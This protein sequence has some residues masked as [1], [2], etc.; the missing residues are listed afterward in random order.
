MGIFKM[1]GIG[2]LHL[3]NPRIPAESLYKK[4]QKTLYPELNDA[5]VLLLTGDIYDQLLTVNSKAH[6]FASIIMRELLSISAH[7]GMQIRLLHGTYTHDRDQLDIFETLQHP[8]SRFKVIN[9][10]DVEELTDIRN[11]DNCIPGSLRILYIPDNLPYKKSEDVLIHCNKVM[12]CHD[13]STVDVVLGHGTFEHVI[14]PDS[15]HRP[16]CLY[17]MEQ[18]QQIN[19]IGPIIMGH[20]HTPSKCGRV[21]YCGSFERMSHGEEEN[22]GFYTFTKSEGDQFWTSRFVVNKDAT[23]FISVAP[24]GDEI[25]DIS[26]DFI[27][28]VEEKFPTRSGNVRVLHPSAEIRAILHKI[29]A[30]QFPELVYSGKASGKREVAELC[31]DEVTLDVLEDITPDVHN[32]GKLRV[33]Y[34]DEKQLLGD[35]TEEEILRRTT[36]LLPSA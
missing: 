20:I 35:V 24:I 15:G 7:T 29:C 23:P 21:Y 9:Q 26:A 6:K 3:G 25:S 28:K 22:K 1:V 16:P 11:G 31:L 30:Q 13:W 4:L 10:I 12:A 32:L 17:R 8:H 2:D 18:F 19:P 27:R 14:P 36:E 5:H 33:Q 34:L